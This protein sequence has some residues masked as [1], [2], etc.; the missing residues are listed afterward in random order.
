MAKSNFIKLDTEM[1]EYLKLLREVIA[2]KSVSTDASYQKEIHKAVQWYKELFLSAGAE[3]EIVS[4]YDNP[5]VIAKF[6]VDASLPTCL[7]YGH[8]DVQPG[9]VDEGW[10]SE[11]FSLRIDD[12]CIYARGVVDNKGQSLIHIY[13]VIKAFRENKLSKNVV[14]LLEGNEETGSPS[15]SD[16]IKD[17]STLLKADLAL[18]SDG[19]IVGSTPVIEAG[20]R[21]GFN[22]TLQVKTADL[23]LHSGI[24]GGTA[25]NAAHELITILTKLLDAKTYKVNIPGFYDDVDAITNDQLKNNK[26]IPFNSKDYKDISGIKATL[27]EEY[28][29]YTQTG[30]LPSVQI[31]GINSGYNGQGYRNGIPAVA[32]AKINFR[33]VKSQSAQKITKQF[34]EFIDKIKPSYA[35]IDLQINDP[36]E[37]VKLDLDNDHI[38]FAAKIINKTFGVDPVYKYSGGGLPIVTYLQDNL[39]I[40]PVLVPLG[41]EDCNMHAINENYNLKVLKSALDFSMLYFTS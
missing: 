33:L 39:R 6:L 5:F 12:Q 7:V 30:L 35:E 36:Y 34:R 22:S 19:E 27:N 1:D 14:F 18:I 29:V 13:S 24:Y 4:G 2:I 38:R 31:T 11:P 40:T 37:G 41:N 16:F 3:V 21:G 9:N 20:F 28:D 8:Y 15:L 17:K 25:P 32:S 10:T 26:S 23:D